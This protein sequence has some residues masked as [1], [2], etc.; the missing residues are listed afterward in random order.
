MG[1]ADL[2]FN[3]IKICNTVVGVLFFLFHAYQFLFVLVPIFIRK[4]KHTKKPLRKY[5]VLISARNEEMVIANLITSLKKQVY[6]TEHLTIFVVADN[7]ADATADVARSAGAIVYERNDTSSVGK[8]YALKYLYERICEDYGDTYFDAYAIFDADNIVDPH[9]FDEINNVLSDKH[10]IVT[11]YRNSKN[12]GDNWISAAYSTWF[13]RESQYLN[14]SRMRCNMACAVSGTG[15]VFDSAILREID[16]WKFFL[17][18]EDIEFTIYNVVKGRKIGYAD[19]AIIYDEQP[20]K[21][22][23]SCQ[24]RMRWAKGYI[25]VMGKYGG[26]LLRGIFSKNWASCFDMSCVIVPALVLGIFSILANVAGGLAI[27]ITGGT[28]L[29]LFLFFGQTLLGMYLIFFLLGIITTVTEWKKIHSSAFKKILY[30]F[31]FPFFMMTYVPIAIAALFSK[32]E[33]KPIEHNNSKTLDEIMSDGTKK[34]GKKECA[35]EAKAEE[36]CDEEDREM[37]EQP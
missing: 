3:I 36:A 11:C 31:S 29:P 1:T 34:K 24:Q 27:A 21:F 25:Q 6:D 20:T 14:R 19:D 17:L 15:Y 23:Q 33:W 16:G 18:T 30:S 22:S 26:G 5:G 8:G 37:S 35:D 7:C 13:L 28:I 4:P 10:P 32:S 12:H 9:F 2:I